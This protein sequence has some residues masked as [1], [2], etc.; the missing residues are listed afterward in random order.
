MTIGYLAAVESAGAIHAWML[1]DTTSTVVDDIGGM[2]GT[3]QGTY[4]GFYPSSPFGDVVGSFYN[5]TNN[6]NATY[7]CA[8]IVNSAAVP[9]DLQ[10]LGAIDGQ[11][12]IGG[13]FRGRGYGTMLYWRSSYPLFEFRDQSTSANVPCSIGFDG[14]KLAFGHS[15]SSAGREYKTASTLGSPADDGDWH[16]V[17]VTRNGASGYLYFDDTR[18]AITL[19][20]QDTSVGAG[21]CNVAVGA[22]FSNSGGT[23]NQGSGAFSGWFIAPS[24]LSQAA[25]ATLYSYK[26]YSPLT[27]AHKATVS[28][29]L[30]PY[31]APPATSRICLINT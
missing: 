1:D 18:E 8:F 25:L 27:K 4:A 14:D 9:A 13:W 6:D 23:V 28:V 31:S 12:T 2:D 11:F 24:E 7:A 30:K 3:W 29:L 15:W 16:F 17:A 19:N 10:A 20:N 22:N 26:G 5:G 21:A